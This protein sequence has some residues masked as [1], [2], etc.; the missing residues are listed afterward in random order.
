VIAS[1]G[2]LADESFDQELCLAQAAVPGVSGRAFIL[3]IGVEVCELAAAI[4]FGN[5]C[6]LI[7]R[8]FAA[9][10]GAGAEHRLAHGTGRALRFNGLPAGAAAPG[11]IRARHERKDRRACAP[12]QAARRAAAPGQGRNPCARQMRGARPA[13]MVSLPTSPRGSPR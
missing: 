8:I 7:K 12:W 5:T 2:V 1:P 6:T 9:F 3:Q 13:G 10:A 4:L 11:T